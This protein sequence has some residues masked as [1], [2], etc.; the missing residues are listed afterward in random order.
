MEQTKTIPEEGTFKVKAKKLKQFVQETND[1]PTINL[2]EPLIDIP[3]NITKV[4][5]PKEDKGTIEQTVVEPK[6]DEGEGLQEIT[7]EESVVVTEPTVAAAEPT[8]AASEEQLPEGVS[9]LLA[10]MK[11]TGGNVQDYVR[12]NTDYTDVDRDVLVKEYY[13]NTKSHLDPEEIDYLI[14]DNFAF[15][16]DLD[17]ERDIRRKK[18]AYKEEVAKARKFLEE[19]KSKYYEDIK[20]KSQVT[21]DQQKATDFFNRHNEDQTKNEESHEQFKNAT[22]DYFTN[23]FKGFDFNV[24]EKKFRYGVSNPES[25]AQ[26]QSDISNFIGG[27]LSEDGKVTDP[28]AY[29]KALYAGANA[30]KMASH[31][32]EQGKADGIKG[33]VNASNNPSTGNRKAA[34]VDGIMM[35]G[36]KI[37]SISGSDSTKLKIKK[38]KN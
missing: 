24:G 2:K 21:P 6:A 7:A 16:E 26:N 30:D 8:I 38:F 13:K 3:S 23:D 22:N 37:K 14:E 19:T 18:L 25:V 27:F 11:E 33:V 1:I 34:P 9:K 15:D 4:V 32:Y 31:F 10:F 36:Y 20:L 35:G 29:H 17:E 12:L 28:A 5:I